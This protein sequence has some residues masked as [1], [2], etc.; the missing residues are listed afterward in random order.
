MPY[1]SFQVTGL[2]EVKV[3]KRKT[4]RSLRLTVTPEGTIRVS[5]PM[6]TPYQA[7][8]SFAL[9]KRAWIIRHAAGSTMRVLHHGQQIGKTH[10]LAFRADATAET[11]RTK[12]GKSDVTITHPSRYAATDDH[13]QK[14]AHT[15]SIRALR[16]QATQLLPTRVY[17]LANRY[18]FTY[19]SLS[20]KQLKSR[21]G[22]CDQQQN[23]VLNLY[24]VQLPWEYIDYV[25]LHELAHT[26]AL[27]HGPD[28]W[29]EFEQVLPH[30]KQL[31][32]R[33]RAFRPMLLLS[34]EHGTAAY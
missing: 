19:H 12:V 16:A 9:T 31:R 20:I 29:Q 5:I 33:M 1:K 14:A 23:I 25:I 26:R 8:V 22:S 4:S 10:W 2:G 21:W 32:R 18:N 15:A 17:T 28:F 27:N 6:W 11:I 34:P 13:V 3:Y 30:A 7:G 24:L